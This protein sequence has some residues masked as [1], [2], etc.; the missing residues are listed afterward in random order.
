MKRIFLSA[1]LAMVAAVLYGCSGL[2]VDAAG[3]TDS[4]MVPLPMEFKG[5]DVEDAI[6]VVFGGVGDEAFIESDANLLP[7]IEVYET[8]GLLKIRYSDDIHLR[9]NRWNHL[10]TIVKVP[11]KNGVNTV[12]V[13]G[14]SS[15]SSGVPFTGTSFSVSAS[16]ASEVICDIDVTDNIMV[17]LSGAASLQCGTVRASRMYIDASGA[18]SFSASGMVSECEMSLSGAS[19][20]ESAPGTDRYSLRLDKCTGDLSGAS[21]AVFCS[22]GFIVCSLSGGSH[23]YFKGGADSKRSDCSGGSSIEWD[24]YLLYE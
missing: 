12:S 17:D 11:Y 6:E 19:S 21:S 9:G 15:F 2:R 24:G 4:T 7:Y 16:G 5:I 23:I 10:H 1:C 8:R 14:A 20:I 22:D 18:S 3:Y 13:S